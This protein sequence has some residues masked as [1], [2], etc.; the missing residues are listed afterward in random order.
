M[1]GGRGVTNSDNA[2]Q[3]GGEGGLKIHH[4]A[5]HPL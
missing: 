2:G 4:L 5:G 3:G 1:S